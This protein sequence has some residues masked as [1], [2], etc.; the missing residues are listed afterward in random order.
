MMAPMA[1]HWPSYGG[2]HP[3]AAAHPAVATHPAMATR[4]P[5]MATS[6]SLHPV[7]GG[8][9]ALN[10][11]AVQ[12]PSVALHGAT[13]SAPQNA[14]LEHPGPRPYDYYE[15]EEEQQWT[16]I[17]PRPKGTLGGNAF[18]APHLHPL[19]T[20]QM[21]TPTGHT[22][23]LTGISAAHQASLGG[24]VHEESGVAP[25][26][27]CISLFPFCRRTAPPP[28]A[29]AAPPPGDVLQTQFDDAV[30]Q[31]VRRV[32]TR[33]PEHLRLGCYAFYKQA[34]EGD[35]P[36]G[37][38]PSWIHQEDRKFYDAWAKQ[39]GLGKQDAMRKYIDTVNLL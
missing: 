25:T 17:F 30:C 23:G 3:A 39:A 10:T 34:T 28:P 6:Q 22:R 38:R 31:A 15:E 35:A 18:L 36:Q 8:G 24:G 27:G 29:V 37:G 4:V 12:S 2:G 13:M 32:A 33:T 21:A 20:T 19:G 26:G 11:A 1:T 16:D 7:L 9:G 14:V 5:A